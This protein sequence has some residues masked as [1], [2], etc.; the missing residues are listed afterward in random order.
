MRLAGLCNGST[1]DSDSVCEGSNPSP[2]AKEKPEDFSSGFFFFSV[3]ADS[4]PHKQLQSRR[5]A[6]EALRVRILHPLPKERR[7][8][9]SLFFLFVAG[10]FPALPQIAFSLRCRLRKS[11]GCRAGRFGFVC[12]R[13][14]LAASHPLPKR[15]QRIFPLIFL[16]L[17]I[18]AFLD[19]L[20]YYVQQYTLFRQSLK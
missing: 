13:Q 8:L 1:P 11:C 18:L 19:T 10:S 15:N 12:P 16:F 17:F 14:R 9:S 7:R 3:L 4:K 2:A 20:Y 6:P 5:A